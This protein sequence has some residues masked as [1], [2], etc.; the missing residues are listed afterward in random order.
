MSCLVE[1]KFTYDHKTYIYCRAR[2]D[3]IG[4]QF[5]ELIQVPVIPKNNDG[6]D[7]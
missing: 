7:D 6:D 3:S 4:K 1:H 2:E 5:P